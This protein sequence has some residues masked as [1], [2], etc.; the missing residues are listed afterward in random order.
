MFVLGLVLLLIGLLVPQFA[1]L[2]T[3]GIVLLL[4]GAVLWVLPSVGGPPVRGPY[5]G[6]W[7]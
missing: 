2:E 4:I 1:I 6:R 7:W 5:R 3:I